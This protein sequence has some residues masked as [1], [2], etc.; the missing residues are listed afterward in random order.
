MMNFTP[1]TKMLGTAFALCGLMTALAGCN[2]HKEEA[3]NGTSVTT[4]SGSKPL[5]IAVIPKGTSHEYWIAIHAGAMKA[6]KELAAQGT[7]VDILWKGPARE[8][9]R[10][11][12]IDVVD[13]FLSQ[14]VSGIVLAPLDSASGTSA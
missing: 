8:D 5:E 3:P 9:D 7:N 10:N 14:Q 4:N 2:G 11:A 13:T 6:A 12:Q 1:M